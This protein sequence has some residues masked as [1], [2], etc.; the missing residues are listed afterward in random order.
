MDPVTQ[1][2]QQENVDITLRRSTREMRPAISSNYVVYL[3]EYDIDIGVEYDLITFSQAIDGSESTLCYNAMKNEM[4]LMANN[5]V[6]DLVELPKVQRSLVVN[7]F[8]KLKRDSSGNI[9]IYKARLVAK[10]FTQKEGID[11]HD[12]FYHVSKNESFWIIMALVAHFDMELHQMDVKT[13]FLN[14]DLEEDVYMKQPK[15]FVSNGNDHMVCKLRNLYM[16]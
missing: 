16:D 12:T 15:G 13:V 2:P 4:N 14:R 5:Q 3:Q 11:Y 9:E 10:G 6:W 7:G 8:L 1:H